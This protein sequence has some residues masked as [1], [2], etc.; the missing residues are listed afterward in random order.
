MAQDLLRAGTDARNGEMLG[1]SAGWPK[2]PRALAGRLRRALTCLRAVGIDIAFSREG[3][4]GT[5]MI[6]IFAA[7]QT[8]PRQTVRT[9]GDH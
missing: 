9:V 8:P 6:R 7:P 2:T 5:R 3:R 1:R 4:A